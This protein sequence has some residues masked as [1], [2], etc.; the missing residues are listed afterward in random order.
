MKA[1]IFE[2]IESVFII[3]ISFLG[4]LR[5]RR[6]SR[7]EDLCRRILVISPSG[8]FARG[9]TPWFEFIWVPFPTFI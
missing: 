7:P 9:V 2:T 3:A 1:F 6:Q 4:I 5:S 8:S